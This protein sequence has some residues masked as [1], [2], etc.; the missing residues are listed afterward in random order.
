MRMTCGSPGLRNRR[1]AFTLVEL[2]VTVVIIGLIAS[3]AIPRLSRGAAGAS[4]AALSYDLMIVRNAINRYAAEHANQFPPAADSDQFHAMMLGYTSMAGQ[5][6]VSRDA[7]HAFGPYLLEVPAC[8]VGPNAGGNEV[9]IDP[10]NSPPEADGAISAAW[11]YNPN[12]GEF[13]ANDIEHE[14]HG[15]LLT[16]TGFDQLLGGLGG[17]DLGG[18]AE[19]G[20]LLG[21]LGGLGGLGDLTP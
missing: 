20:D 3:M 17:A 8:S 12:T 10:D 1:A 4:G 5:T 19:G 2:V 15:V 9:H 16:G 14:Q 7:G 11:L 18:D 21:G 13:Y 6:R